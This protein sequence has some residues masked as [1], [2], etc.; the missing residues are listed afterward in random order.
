MKGLGDD[1]DEVWIRGMRFIIRV[2][3]VASHLQRPRKNRNFVGIETQLCQL[4]IFLRLGLGLGL[5]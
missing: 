4:D 3:R 2:M 1:G 5:E